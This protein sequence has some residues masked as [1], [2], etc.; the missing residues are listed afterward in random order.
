VK[1]KIYFGR[2]VVEVGKI[3]RL[4]GWKVQVCVNRAEKKNLNA[5]AMKKLVVVIV[6]LSVVEGL[7][8]ITVNLEL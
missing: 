2:F 8:T 7:L 3:E 5:K 6:T 4:K 1:G